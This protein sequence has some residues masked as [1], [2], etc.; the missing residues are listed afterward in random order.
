MALRRELGGKDA[1]RIAGLTVVVAMVTA[2][3]ARGV[4]SLFY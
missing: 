2:L 1:A 3:M 4:S